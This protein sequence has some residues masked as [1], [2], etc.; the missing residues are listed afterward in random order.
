MTCPHC[1]ATVAPGYRFCGSCRKRVGL[2]AAS[3]PRGPV[4][5]SARTTAPRSVRAPATF[6]R[7]TVIT[8]LGI[9][10]ILGGSLCLLG[11]AAVLLVA[12][13]PEGPATMAAIGAAYAVVGVLQLATG[14]GLLR[15]EPWAR[16]LQ[17]GL[18]VVGLLG[19]PCGT[20]ISILILVYMLK[21]EVK[22]LFSGV[23]PSQLAPQEL[24]MVQRLSQGS[25]VTVAIVVVAVVII[26]IAGVGM[27]AAI[28]IPSLLR[29][30]VSAN[31][32]ATIGD[33]RTMISAQAAYASANWGHGDRPECLAAPSNCIPDY[34]PDAPYFLDSTL[35]QPEQR[36]GYR[37]RFL[38]GPTA[39]LREGE[40]GSPSSLDGWAY[41]AEP[42]VLNQ[43]GV[44]AFCADAS[45]LVC[46]DLDGA[47]PDASGGA[48]PS[49]CSPLQ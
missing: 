29:A 22:L 39:E 14:I 9:L 35:L 36:H 47:M 33:L 24:E 25:G 26:G 10:G 6:A 12:W 37:F 8:V 19:I 2:D 34:P 32:S 46:S 43:T 1:G 44:R 18:A 45:G 23:S 11:A 7:P 27:V 13:G 17:I 38:P 5:T 42:I 48:C 40:R 4:Q 28:A 31:E 15:L 16:T 3:G 30:R 41:L 49:S 20:I 21:P